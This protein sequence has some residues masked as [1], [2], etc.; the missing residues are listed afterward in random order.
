[1]QRT[2]VD[3]SFA[4]AV[5]VD[6]I[7]DTIQPIR[8][9]DAIDSIDAIVVVAIIII[10]WQRSVHGV[11]ERIERG[12]PQPVRPADGADGLVELRRLPELHR[13]MAREVPRPDAIIIDDD[14]IIIDAVEQWSVDAIDG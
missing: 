14:A 12:L 3:A 1:M 6:A 13:A 9:V 4:S 10:V 7:V 8:A 11:R 2:S 5:I